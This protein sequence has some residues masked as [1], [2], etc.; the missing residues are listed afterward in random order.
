M[1]MNRNKLKELYPEIEWRQSEGLSVF[2]GYYLECPVIEA[3]QVETEFEGE[4]RPAWQVTVPMGHISV[5]ER[6]LSEALEK[7]KPAWDSVKFSL[8]ATVFKALADACPADA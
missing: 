8:Q 5:V 6:R 1:L 7:A 2:D 3:R 4:T